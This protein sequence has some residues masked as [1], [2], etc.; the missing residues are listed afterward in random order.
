V[1]LRRLRFYGYAVRMWLRFLPVWVVLQLV[2][3]LRFVLLVAGGRYPWEAV[4]EIRAHEREV[5]ERFQKAWK[6]AGLP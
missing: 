6:A 1:K 2:R 3:A 5:R 4:R